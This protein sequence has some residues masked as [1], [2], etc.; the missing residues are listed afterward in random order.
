M[1]Y[2]L[3]VAVE[4]PLYSLFSYSHYRKLDL[5]VRVKVPLGRGFSRGWVLKVSRLEEER[6]LK[7]IDEVIDDSPPL[8]STWLTLAQIISQEY[9]YPLGLTLKLLFPY[10]YLPSFGEITLKS[11]GE[12]FSRL[13]VGSRLSRL[14]YYREVIGEFLAAG[15]KVILLVPQLE[16]ME[17]WA[18]KLSFDNTF[19]WYSEIRRSERKRAWNA[20]KGEGGA[21]FI[22]TFSLSLVP[23]RNLGLVIV[24]D[25]GSSYLRRLSLPYI[26]A[27]DAILLRRRVESFSVV[28]GGAILSAESFNLVKEGWDLEEL[29][30]SKPKYRLIDLKRSSKVAFLSQSLFSKIK[31]NLKL[32]GKSVILLNRKAYASYLKCEECGYIPKCS[33]CDIP[34]SL[35]REEGKLKCPYCGYERSFSD[36]CFNCGG[37][38]FKL[39]S[40][41][42]ESL[43]S[44]LRRRLGSGVAVW[45]AETELFDESALII[46]GTQR[47]LQPK[48]M[49]GVKLACIALAD[50]SLY[51]SSYRSEEETLRMIY[52]LASFSPE[53]LYVQTYVPEHPVFKIFREDSWKEFLEAELDKRKELRYP[54]FYSLALVS[55]KGKRELFLMSKLKELKL[56]LEGRAIEVLGP[57]R[58]VLPDGKISL[59]LLLKGKKGEL[60]KELCDL[61]ENG[62]IKPSKELEIIVDPPEV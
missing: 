61:L 7:S 62:K 48:I 4:R 31:A 60:E 28:L 30:G 22:G 21:L 58:R 14:S 53:E 13:V 27:R 32:G 36:T 2:V 55:L 47:V 44:L 50:L 42:I 41:G 59:S 46:V 26:H 12:R 9:C 33:N 57:I 39:G 43:A 6:D 16:D 35:Y 5:G 38:F 24:D 11:V 19:L 34:L 18:S 1:R 49:N 3:D 52:S 56:A 23:M 29:P 40:P 8:P 54:P 20:A 45:D 51:K 17:D 10:D 25:E 37:Y 15:E